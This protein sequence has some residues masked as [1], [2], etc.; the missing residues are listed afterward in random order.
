MFDLEE[1]LELILPIGA[2]I[3]TVS[4]R[5][6]K[7]TWPRLLGLAAPQTEQGNAIC[8]AACRFDRPE[9]CGWNALM[10]VHFVWIGEN[11]LI[12][13]RTAIHRVKSLNPSL[14]EA[15]P[16][17]LWWSMTQFPM[18]AV[19]LSVVCDSC[20]GGVGVIATEGSC[21]EVAGLWCSGRGGTRRAELYPTDV[22]WSDQTVFAFAEK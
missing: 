12:T 14:T 2:R 3:H 11:S 7:Y 6:N 18:L 9:R 17:H 5:P 4:V 21:S 10:R 13:P 16:Y 8:A 19:Q 22:A 15:S 1:K 20:D